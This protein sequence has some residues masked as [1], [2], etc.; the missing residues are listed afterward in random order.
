MTTRTLLATL[1]PTALALALTGAPARGQAP[2]TAS[3]R[4]APALPTARAARLEGA[5]PVVDG[6]L[7]DAAWAGVEPVG[8]FVQ[9]R[10]RAGSPAT[11]RTEVRVV[12]GPDAL[13][14]GARLFDTAPD[15]VVGQ[16][17]RRD[18]EGYSD[19]FSVA[20]DSYD[21]DRTAF[22]FAVNPRG[23]KRDLLF[24]NDSDAD[25]G[26]DAVWDGAARRDSLGWVAEL[27][28]PFSQL[29]FSAAAGERVW[30][31]NFE[32][33][34]ARRGETAY[35]APILPDAPGF[36][37]R[38]GRLE[39]I[40][41]I[42]TPRRV[43][44]QPYASSRLAR[45]PSET[46]N[47]FYRENDLLG[48]VGAD[49]KYGLTSDLTLT[50][51][52]NPDFGQV[53]VDPAE[54][55]LSA[56]E[57]FFDER[58]PFFL[59]GMEA[60]QFGSARFNVATSF[61][62]LFYSRRIGQA[63]QRTLGGRDFAYV[64]AP[65]QTTIAAA[66]KVSGRLGRGWTLG[67]LDAVTAPEEARY[68]DAGGT[69]G[70]AA[71]EP[72]S[73]YLVGR[74]RRDAGEGSWLGGYLTAVNRHL[75]DP[76]LRGM[77]RSAAYV[78]GVDFER[79]W[80]NRAWI[81][82]GSLTGSRVSGSSEAVS[83]A[84]L[85]ST[86]YF[87]RPDADHVEHDPER[88][89][90]SGHNLQLS[91]SKLGGRH[92]RTSVWYQELSPGF[93]VND[94]GFQSRADLR[95][96]TGYLAYQENRPGPL[97]RSYGASGYLLG[98]WNFAGD[99]TRLAGRLGASG[100]LKSFW[101]ISGGVGFA[102]E[103]YDDRLTRGGPLARTPADAGYDLGLNTDRRKR[104][105]LQARLSGGASAAGGWSR[106]GSLS[107]EARPTGAVQLSVGP[108]L[109]R[110]RGMA[111]YVATVS[112][113]LAR[114][115]YGKRYVFA[116]LERTSLSLPTRLNWTFSPELSLQLYLQPL[117]DAGDYGDYKE[118]SAPRTFDF[119][120]YGS[121]RGSIARDDSTGRYTVDPDGKEGLARAF[122]FRDRDYN[123][124]SLRGNA[125]LR[126]EYRPGS[127]LFFV[128]QQQRSEEVLL[129]DF[130]LGR[131]SGAWLRA[132]AESVFLLKLTYWLGL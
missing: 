85:R 46:G 8:S 20:V 106:S 70:R 94:L 128:W 67:V 119:Q 73:N 17:T 118:L 88:T 129:G 31:I 132:P 75:D 121:D 120:V 62:R 72:L 3:V 122:G 6:R 95:A 59:E 35:W 91:L 21:D 104:L 78:G 125:V 64:D 102:P 124:R 60:F 114:D 54:V 74:L 58:R 123:F 110:R 113:S 98:T 82:A 14:V 131:D 52:L 89:S 34:I 47:P 77:A 16:L 37:S 80:S 22:L 71:V 84:Q 86:R 42:A 101:G 97:F 66:A 87:Q 109:E 96:L 43:E 92:W 7:E 61:P 1:V 68:Q 41:E 49:L 112:D 90:L 26:W 105:S 63:P 19:W 50:A 11:E 29:R 69:P 117:I 10:P 4:A 2:D 33:E 44:V 39:G 12:Y 111:Q 18:A 57:T 48:S 28:I 32:R 38:F 65:A 53:E 103:T 130:D 116:T 99:H 127:T 79:A 9:R 100:T 36:V 15:S 56:F 51:T 81:L 45:A 107:L 55:N 5:A 76:A 23:V 108:A 13:Y 93:E 115:T 24:F 30:G 27:R 40:G 25:D 83:A 126:W